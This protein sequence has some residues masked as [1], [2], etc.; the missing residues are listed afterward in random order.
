MPLQRARFRG[1]APAHDFQEVLQ[2]FKNEGCNLLVTG[3]V[4][5]D[6]TTHATRTLLGSP[7]VD[8]KRV[9][10][11]AD[12]RNGAAAER[13]PS[14][15]DPEGPDVWL[16]DQ[17]TRRRSVPDAARNA[18]VRFPTDADGGD[19]L[20]RLREEIV[21]AIDYYFEAAADGL[22]PADLRLSV[23]SL[24]RLAH[25]HGPDDLARFV[26]GVGAMVLGVRGMAHYHLPRPDDDELVDRL[27]PLFDARV[28]LRRRD[29]LP[30]EQ[31]WHVP[32]YGRTTDW[33]RL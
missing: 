12:A 18:D 25:E 5:E 30:T 13:L 8:R 15:V 2:R 31:R 4:S 14:G 24:D 17:R 21:T 3:A 22:D 1:D 19:A 32:E 11:L 29:G 6:V 27:S 9:V 28:E 33:V 7:D 16:V 20:V 26:R 23:A 10:A